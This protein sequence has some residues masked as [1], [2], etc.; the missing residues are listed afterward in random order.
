MLDP[1]RRIRET[2]NSPFSSRHHVR[3]ALSVL[4]KESQLQP[5][6]TDTRFALLLFLLRLQWD[7][8][9]KITFILKALSS[10]DSLGRV[11][12]TKVGS[13]RVHSFVPQQK[14]KRDKCDKM[15]TVG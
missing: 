8:H 7:D 6:R 10:P 11:N 1:V 4:S 5:A 9:N 14:S 12:P 15:M 2:P 13:E 3:R